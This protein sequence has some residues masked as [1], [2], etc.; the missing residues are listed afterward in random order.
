MTYVGDD[1][2]LRVSIGRVTRQSEGSSACHSW[3]LTGDSG[4]SGDLMVPPLPIDEGGCGAL[5][6]TDNQGGGC[7]WRPAP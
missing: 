7:L 6:V 5:A 2:Q 3:I 1:D 4:D